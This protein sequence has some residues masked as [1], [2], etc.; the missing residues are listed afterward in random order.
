MQVKEIFRGP[1]TAA[2][3]T[4]PWAGCGMAV[5]LN[6]YGRNRRD[7]RQRSGQFCCFSLGRCYRFRSRRSRSRTSSGL[8]VVTRIMAR[9]ASAS[10]TRGTS[11]STAASSTQ[12]VSCR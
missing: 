3:A 4:D 6:N 9:T 10:A 2:A 5:K 7:R 11:S 8:S 12:R 1:G